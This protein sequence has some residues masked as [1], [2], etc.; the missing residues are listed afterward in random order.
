MDFASFA[1]AALRSSAVLPCES[2]DSYWI[3]NASVQFGLKSVKCTFR[4]ETSFADA[5]DEAGTLV[6][7]D[8]RHTVYILWVSSCEDPSLLYSC[9]MDSKIDKVALRYGQRTPSILK[10]MIEGA[11]MPSDDPKFTM[12]NLIGEQEMG[13]FIRLCVAPGD[14]PSALRLALR[15]PSAAEWK[16]HLLMFIQNLQNDLWKERWQRE[17]LEKDALS[18]KSQI[19]QMERKRGWLEKELE[20]LYA[21]MQQQ[22][23]MQSVKIT[24]EAENSIPKREELLLQPVPTASTAQIT[25]TEESS[26]FNVNAV[27]SKRSSLS[28]S[29]TSSVPLKSGPDFKKKR[30]VRNKDALANDDLLMGVASLLS[31]A[32]CPDEVTLRDQDGIKEHF[33]NQHLDGEHGRCRACTEEVKSS[34]MLSHMKAHL[35]KKY[36]CEFCGKKGRKHYLKAHIR[37]HTGERP[38]KCDKCPRRFADS[39]T[40]RRHQLIH[41][42]EKRYSCPVCGRCIARKDNV[43]THLR[44]HVKTISN[45]ESEAAAWMETLLNS[46]PTKM[47]RNAV[48]VPPLDSPTSVENNED[49]N[50][51]GDFN[52][53]ESLKEDEEMSDKC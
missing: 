41:T 34:D 27:P 13:L 47:E 3:T 53:L 46:L 17:L 20:M 14:G 29:L 7:G 15:T 18:M 38:Y 11:N 45:S 30:T 5:E 9:R 44:S 49:Q 52:L 21:V 51:L 10:N 25:D 24:N 43:K 26:K 6:N 28:S 4:F 42:G 32:V 37:V 1:A 33:I 35:V 12:I 22:N 8:N 36:A 39:S 48:T 19:A 50:L 31:C 23:P 2:F 40:F 16:S